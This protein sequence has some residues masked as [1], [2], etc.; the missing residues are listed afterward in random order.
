MAG[1]CGGHGLTLIPQIAARDGGRAGGGIRSR[2]RECHTDTVGNGVRRRGPRSVFAWG[3]LTLSISAVVAG[4]T[5]IL[6]F[7][8][9]VGARCRESGTRWGDSRAFFCRDVM[10]G[11]VWPSLPWVVVVAAALAITAGLV[12]GT[13]TV[14]RRGGR[15]R[16][17]WLAS[18][19][20]VYALL[21]AAAAWVPNGGDVDADVA[22][23]VLPL[24]A[25]LA[26]GLLMVW[27]AITGGVAAV[28]FAVRAGRR[29]R[30]LITPVD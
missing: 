27:G 11:V 28:V 19:A 9:F 6:F 8:A 21:L 4:G 2:L 30:E 13:M 20:L 26:T 3:W 16:G 18:T 1:G 12:G 10:S 25:A 7:I 5:V 14:L 17:A 23:E 24:T 22:F 29:G 15:L